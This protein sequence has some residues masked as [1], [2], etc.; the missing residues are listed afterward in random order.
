MAP[1]SR[2]SHNRRVTTFL[3]AIDAVRRARVWAKAAPRFSGEYLFGG[4]AGPPLVFG[5]FGDSLGCG[6]GA[7]DVGTSFAGVVAGKLTARGRVLCRIAAV[8][9]AQGPELAD[10]RVA[11]DER[12]VAVSIGTNDLLHGSPL[13]RFESSL[14]AFLTRVSHAERVV[15][16][17][18][19]NVTAVSIF[20]AALLP[21]LKR[22]MVAWEDAM[23]AVAARFPNAVHVGPSEAGV[24][25]T[26]EH[27]AEDGFHPGDLGQGLIAEAV[28]RRLLA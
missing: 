23:K 15:V 25:L 7:T 5:V 4:Q 8:S 21:L 16:L 14:T 2:E 10:Q 12:I 26:R 27:F 13:R 3:E 28:Y 20:P 24:D 11:G 6:I 22:R 1:G 19:G 9:G 18:P 17:G